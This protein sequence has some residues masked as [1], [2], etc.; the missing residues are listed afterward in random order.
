MSHRLV[1]VVG[2]VAAGVVVG[3]VVASAQAPTLRTYRFSVDDLAAPGTSTPNPPKVVPAPDGAALVAPEGFVVERFAA[4]GLTRP[5]VARQ[6]PNGDIFVVDTGASS[7]VVLR[8]ANGNQRIEENER[9]VFASD[10]KQPFGLAFQG[11]AVYVA[12][13]DAVLRFPYTAGQ[14]TAAGPPTTVTPLPSGKGGH[15]TRNLAFSPD[16]R[17]FYVTV[18]SSSNVDVEPDP[19]RATVLRF[20]ADGSNRQVVMSGVRNAVGLDAHPE[21]GEFWISVQERDGLGDHLVHDYVA[22]VKDGVSH[23]WPF[24]YLGSHEDPRHAG[25]RPD[26]VKAAVAPDVLLEPHSSVLGL[27]FYDHTAFPAKYRNGA[28]AALRGSSGRTPR[29][30]YKVVF[31]PF[32]KGQPTGGYEDFVA[33]WMLGPD[34]PEVWGRPVDVTVLRDGSLLVVEDANHSLWRVSRA[35]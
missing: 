25:A 16:G 11:D 23:G 15:W 8:D 1:P 20:D 27:A 30:G 34:Q 29:T 3:L 7:V 6:A 24:A 9:H 19:L 18:G 33:G 10:L 22:R 2:L 13:T 21:T 5:R 28:F 31:L 14:T 4:D 35:R 17:H 26:I 12:N 32:E